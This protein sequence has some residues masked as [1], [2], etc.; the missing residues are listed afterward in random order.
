MNNEIYVLVVKYRDYEYDGTDVFVSCFSTKE[1]AI[2]AL[3]SDLKNY[4]NDENLWLADIE[5]EDK[6]TLTLSDTDSVNYEILEW[7][8]SYDCVYGLGIYSTNGDNLELCFNI[9]KQK[10]NFT[11]L[12]NLK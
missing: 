5:W 11:E 10:V 1:L 4:L 9:E 3:E 12:K 7:G 8:E 2:Q 6:E